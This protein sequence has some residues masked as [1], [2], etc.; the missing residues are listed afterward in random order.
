MIHQESTMA[1][2]KNLGDLLNKV[3]YRHDSI[4][5][6]K[7]GHPIA[8]IIDIELFQKIWLMKPEFEQLIAKFKQ[9]YQGVSS[10]VA[11]TE[12]DEAIAA[13]RGKSKNKR[14]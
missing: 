8:A 12:I 11:E 3:Q 2:R 4:L 5:I 7:L 14:E 9:T 1:V 10:A 13:A 6:T